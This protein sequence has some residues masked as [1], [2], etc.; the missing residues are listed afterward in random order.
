MA[1]EYSIPK[2]D[3]L[4]NSNICNTY[5]NFLNIRDDSALIIHISS[6]NYWMSGT[7][8]KFIVFQ[9]NGI[10]RLYEAFFPSNKLK[11]TKLKKIKP[12]KKDIEYYWDFLSDYTSNLKYSFNDSLLNIC[13][14]QLYD[15]ISLSIPV[16]RDGTTYK[17]EIAKGPKLLSYSTI[18]PYTYIRNE[19]PGSDERKK[20]MER[21]IEISN[22][23]TKY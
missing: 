10:V 18:A 15:T 19:Y 16:V 11:K 2:I 20:F 3:N 22:M 1:Q 21:F 8:S 6:S 14:K 17:I 4:E 9:N 13:K 12:K 5:V 23:F 7:E